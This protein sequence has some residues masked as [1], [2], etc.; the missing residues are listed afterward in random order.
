MTL[1]TSSEKASPQ[2]MQSNPPP[3][4]NAGAYS[5]QPI[6]TWSFGSLPDNAGDPTTQGKLS[7]DIRR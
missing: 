7:L 2:Q 1:V 4:G 5:D 3:S 6:T